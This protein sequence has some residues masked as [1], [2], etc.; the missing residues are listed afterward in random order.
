MNILILAESVTIHTNFERVPPFW[1]A[2]GTH[3][4]SLFGAF[5]LKEFY[6]ASTM[7]G[8]EVISILTK[9]S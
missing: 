4:T 8:D 7:V 6:L 1:L 3:D 2:V 9:I 5:P